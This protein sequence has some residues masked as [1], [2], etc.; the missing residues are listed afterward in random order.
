[1]KNGEIGAEF[2]TTLSLQIAQQGP[3]PM[4]VAQSSLVTNQLAND[5]VVDTLLDNNVWEIDSEDN[6]A[7]IVPPQPEASDPQLHVAPF[8]LL[9]KV[10]HSLH[11]SPSPSNI[12]PGTGEESPPNKKAREE[13]CNCLTKENCHN[14]KLIRLGQFF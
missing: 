2:S 5:T 8:L 10:S 13:F 12:V 7:P 6:I 3:L 14:W 1:M 9:R 4:I 11:I